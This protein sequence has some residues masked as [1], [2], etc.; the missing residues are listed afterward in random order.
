MKQIYDYTAI[1]LLMFIN[2]K[3]EKETRW[4]ASES[5][6][7]VKPDPIESERFKES[8]GLIYKV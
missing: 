4:W 8:I 6:I 2:V 5:L 1:I 3:Y 7:H